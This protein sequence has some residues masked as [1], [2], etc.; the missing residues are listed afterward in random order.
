MIE[1]S[2]IEEFILYC[3]VVLLSVRLAKD[4]RN[5]FEMS[6]TKASC[7]MSVVSS[8]HGAR[9]YLRKSYLSVWLDGFMW[10]KF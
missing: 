8:T 4:Y 10:S 6:H 9:F 7:R 3:V 2:Y 5:I 1:E